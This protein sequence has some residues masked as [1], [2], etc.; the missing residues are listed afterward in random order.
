MPASRS[1]SPA[2]PPLDD[3]QE[4]DASKAQGELSK[5][6]WDLV[7]EAANSPRS[8][9]SVYG[10]LIPA[11]LQYISQDPSAKKTHWFCSKD[12]VP[13]T[14]LHTCMLRIL[15][16]TT[17]P[18]IQQ[19]LRSLSTTL[20]SCIECHKGYLL[21]KEDLASTFLSGFP[22]E[23]VEKFMD[24]IEKW[25]EGLA[26][27]LFVQRKVQ[28]D[29]GL[30][31]L[32]PA[33]LYAVLSAVANRD[34]I[35]QKVHSAMTMH[36]LSST[37]LEVPAGLLRMAISDDAKE[38]QWVAI[39]MQS[40]KAAPM[41]DKIAKTRAVRRILADLAARFTEADAS[42]DARDQLWHATAQICTWAPASPSPL[43]SVV[44]A[45]LDDDSERISSIL[46]A[47]DAVLRDQ[48]S[49]IWDRVT[50]KDAEY[51]LVLL[52]SVLDN[53][54]FLRSIS[55]TADNAQAASVLAWMSALLDALPR[56]EDSRAS[57][58]VPA[59]QA[60]GT[61]RQDTPPLPNARAHNVHA[62]VLKRVTHFLLERLQHPHITARAYAMQRG[63]TILIHEF[64]SLDD[65]A[66]PSMQSMSQNVGL[67]AR[68]IAALAFQGTLPGSTQVYP[69]KDPARQA[70]QDLVLLLLDA[71]QAVVTD[72][73]YSLARITQS[74]LSRWRRRRKP[75]QPDAEQLYAAAAKE[76]YP[77]PLIC[78]E[79]WS[80]A[81]QS[82]TALGNAAGVAENATLFLKPLASIALLGEP[83]LSTHLLASPKVESQTYAPYKQV[84]KGC[85]VGI[86]RRLRAI[87]GDLPAMLTELSEA[88]FGS[89]QQS[90][91][92]LCVRLSQEIMIFN[93]S[94]IPELH[95][96]AQNLVRAAYPHVE[97]RADVFR[98]LL[99]ST[100]SSLLGIESALSLFVQACMNL[101]EANDAA[102]WIVRSCADVLEVLCSR[103]NG[104]L[105]SGAE[106]SYIDRG[107]EDLQLVE[108]ALP[109]VWELMCRSV[110]AIFQKTPKWSEHIAKEDMVA[111][112][113]DVNIFSSQLA[114][115]VAT[116]QSAINSKR[117][118]E[119]RPGQAFSDEE[120]EASDFIVSCLAL[121][122]E[123]AMSWLRINDIEIVN[124]TMQFIIKAL[125][126][127]RDDVE[128]PATARDSM[129]KFV[130]EQIEVQKA[131]ER[132][133]LLSVN[134]L[135][136]LQIRLDPRS[137]AISISDSD[138]EDSDS[139]AATSTKQGVKQSPKTDSQQS[140]L[141]AMTS[142][143]KAST[144]TASQEKELRTKQRKLRQQKLSFGPASAIDVDALDT[145]V[146]PQHK[147]PSVAAATRPS[148]VLPA[149]KYRSAGTPATP[150]A[151]KKG[152]PPRIPN[153]NMA[154]LRQQFS[155]AH[156]RFHS[157][158]R[159]PPAAVS[160]HL[161]DMKQPRAPVASNTLH[162]A[163][164]R[165]SSASKSL[166]K[167]AAD[168]DS[169][170]ES[171]E[172]DGPKGLAALEQAAESQNRGRSKLLS[173]QTQPRRTKL[174]DDGAIERARKERQEAE[175]KRRL[176]A[177]TDLRP[178][179]QSILEWD[180]YHEGDVPPAPPSG[181]AP[182]YCSIPFK[183]RNADEYGAVFGP[184][185]LL[186]CWAQFLQAK[187]DFERGVVPMYTCEIQGRVSIDTFVDVSATMTT[188][189]PPS[190][191]LNES[192]I[193]ILRQ[194][195]DALQPDQRS[196]K[197][198]VLLA[199][200]ETFKRHGQG[201]Q[202]ALRCV[203]NNDTQAISSHLV[204]RSVWEIG[205]L[206]SLSTVNREFA[207]LL[208]LPFYDLVRDITQGR[209]APR[210]QPSASDVKTM[211]Q[212]YGVNVP[213]AEAILGALH[214][215]G[216]SL[217]QGP[218][219]TGKT[220]TIC[221]LVAHFVATR[222]TPQ[223]IGTG[224][225]AV[226]QAIPKK[227]LMCAPSNAAID[228]VARRAKMG[229]KGPDG[230]DIKVN[231]VRL[232]RDDA[233]NVA[234][235]DISLDNLVEQALNKS[236]GQLSDGTTVD[237]LLA[238]VR[239][240]RDEKDVKQGE[241]EEA[242]TSGNHAKAKNLEMEIRALTSKRMTA[243]QKLDEARDKRQSAYR[244]I[245]ADRRRVRNEILLNADV[246][247]STL[248]GAGHEALASL[249]I[250]FETVVIDEAAQAVELSTI[251]P[252]RYGCKRCI[253]VGD[254]NQLPPTVISTKADKLQY[255]RSLF[256]RMFEQAKD[257]IYLLSIQYRM[258]PEIS[259]HPSQTFYDGKLEDGP[260]MARLTTRPW[261]TD[262]LL[263]PFRFFSVR[264]T[265]RSSRGHSYMNTDEAQVA[266][267]IYERLKRAAPGFDFDGKVGCVT[268]YKGQVMELKRAFTNRYGSG[269]EERIDFNTVDG[270]QGQEKDIII[271]SC[272]RSGQNGLGFLT[273]ARRINVAVT[274]AKSSLFIVGNAEG[275]RSASSPSGLW[276]HLVDYSEDRRALQVTT[277]GTFSAP[278]GAQRGGPSSGPSSGPSERKGG[279]ARTAGWIAADEQRQQQH[280]GPT[281][282]QP[283]GAS[284]KGND[285]RSNTDDGGR[286]VPKR[287]RL[288]DDDK[289]GR[290][291][292]S[293][294][295]ASNPQPSP[296]PPL[297]PGLQTMRPGSAGRPV[298]SSP[299]QPRPP[300]LPQG[301][302]TMRP[303]ARPPP[304]PMRPNGQD[305]RR[306]YNGGGP[307]Q[308][309][310]GG[311]TRV[312]RP[313]QPRPP[314]GGGGVNC[315]GPAVIRPGMSGSQAPNGNSSRIA[316]ALPR[317]AAAVTAP[318][319]PRPGPPPVRPPSA[320]AGPSV[321]SQAAMD[322]LFVKKR[323]R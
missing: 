242:R 156:S 135:V 54:G 27:D 249:P 199:K 289:D 320:G 14:K 313:G 194:R 89:S 311:G 12:G 252:L 151:A 49:H 293:P 31:F 238:E 72:A 175:R 47:F 125:D 153:S 244:Q 201:T 163:A 177:P 42:D 24:H 81:Y 158:V 176:R 19:W 149:N 227:L 281:R 270:F 271:L 168:S 160:H 186:E 203:I 322:A 172:D 67:Y 264:G 143:T 41:S 207:A 98:A 102:K 113:R 286:D 269:I 107:A 295:P 251:I 248:S 225:R 272:V 307:P 262:H 111:W 65:L 247:C 88:D 45:H 38:R 298:A 318:P 73:L 146:Q 309:A 290:P 304:P 142:P 51:P 39:Q 222:K 206:F 69:A 181:I 188:Q 267:A 84:V 209:V 228:E 78:H 212:T 104:L 197:P 278:L 46:L 152:P 53:P 260:D 250:D 192:D 265:E 236:A 91:A 169:S 292:A 240:L 234:V 216:F 138:G 43:T 147:A 95:N 139:T 224:G 16:F 246:I 68:T 258:H 50:E 274:R 8:S 56:P 154:A 323:K 86:S 117:R 256:V 261:H 162:T 6:V 189:T 144:T 315:R 220:K 4:D 32:S 305:Q 136:D 288:D 221:A 229:M 60:A 29:G 9:T 303:S 64:E 127:F 239:S 61:R 275:L 148:G 226:A 112:F 157:G 76:T 101:V 217:I 99:S 21:A 200:V 294:H 231:V 116:V 214:G 299:M 193:I 308:S 3:R 268:M 291:A 195:Q 257:Q 182:D 23:T 316:P 35:R 233:M 75:G 204:N 130:R 174:L 241:L 94:P 77:S 100:T 17:G 184:M 232:G 44:L 314:H 97:S 211:V 312:V 83:Q 235:K 126:C 90:V 297:P 66:S 279:R 218:P 180:W 28:P 306:P 219:G 191:R 255:S 319:R 131:E 15:S 70:A 34:Q 173:G 321:P 276:R 280:N 71:D 26:L 266:V 215:Q 122:L 62:E 79:L 57:L 167:K 213:Q 134:D 11:A 300:P 273:D 133:T 37:L 2:T 302:Q 118:K 301:M 128:L 52:S 317:T 10:Q 237:Q 132:K 85:L 93:L 5:R 150:S 7:A 92:E 179:H 58:S 13:E 277:R 208:T 253:L 178:L 259:Y 120:E 159:R 310:H 205:A 55:K 96:A 30:G 129:L 40:K 254:P 59:D 141:A 287:P 80:N 166:P 119:R 161:N 110:A 187:E 164:S 82:F 137:R 170:S 210:Q 25:E 284:H 190:F 230:K 115:Q 114:E 155:S 171:E 87:R 105:R 1:S 74:Q 20:Y 36:Q 202:L 124:E 18:E 196:P 121:P 165:T 33:E 109:R 48:G 243:S 285:S 108:D 223:N 123:Q 296:R 183:F 145:K 283:N 282:H 140:W 185:L 245:D 103:T 106:H 198:R 22:V 63:L 263:Q